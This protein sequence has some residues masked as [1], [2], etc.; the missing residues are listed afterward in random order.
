MIV[1]RDQRRPAKLVAAAVALTAAALGVLVIPPWLISMIPKSMLVQGTLGLLTVL[2][3]TYVALWLTALIATPVLG[4]VVFRT[5]QSRSSPTWVS[6]GLLLGTSCLLGLLTAEAI[7]AARR[8]ATRPK[9]LPTKSERKNKTEGTLTNQFDE[10]RD[11]AE[12][13]LAVLGESSA[14]GVPYSKWLSIGRILT[15]QLEQA[16]PGKRFHLELLAVPGDTLKGQYEKLACLSRRPDCVIIYCGHNE[17]FSTIP[18]SRRPDHYRDLKGG[19]DWSSVLLPVRVSSVLGLIRQ[20]LEQHRVG[21]GPHPY[22]PQPLVDVPAYMPGDFSERLADF[23]FR[24]ESITAYTESIKAL[25]I[26][27]VPPA[28][29]ADFD[30]NRSFLPAETPRSERD[31]FAREFLDA[32]RLEDRER[33]S[34]LDRYRSLLKRQPG[35]AE[36]HYR[37]GRLLERAGDWAGAYEHYV[38]ARDC[39]GLPMRCP[40]KFQQVYREVASRHDCILIDGQALFHAIGTHGLLTDDLFCDAIHPSLRGHIALAQAI[41]EGMRAHHA[42]RWTAEIPVPPIDPTQCAAHFGLKPSDMSAVAM[43]ES[44][45][46]G[47]VALLRYDPSQRRA[48]ARALE[49][50]ARRIAA[51][52]SAESVGLSDFGARLNTSGP[53]LTTPHLRFA[54]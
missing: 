49:R 17:F 31:A 12:L 23:A 40:S 2:E 41:L 7:V 28:N 52:E 5:R 34:A 42:F 36:T 6:R 43:S 35:F 19:A 45:F 8:A 53:P 26:L 4:G 9:L 38:A 22:A 11:D 50:A 46:Y 25:P 37:L 24:L 14:F 29:D 48:K 21:E 39:D 44:A 1:C 13:T 47:G 16:K 27:V 18:S 30:P 3:A 54:P 32:R 20:T 10:P 51:G 15:W 33:Q